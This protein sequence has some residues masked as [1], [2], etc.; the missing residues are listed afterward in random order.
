[1]YCTAYIVGVSVVVLGLVLSLKATAVRSRGNEAQTSRVAP[2]FSIA[3]LFLNLSSASFSSS[4]G[5]PL[6]HP[7]LDPSSTQHNTLTHTHTHILARSHALSQTLPHTYS[8]TLSRTHSLT[9]T[10]TLLAVNTQK[11]LSVHPK[12]GHTRTHTRKLSVC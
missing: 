5:F 8:P 1:M 7:A 12:C 4:G 9:H 2:F 3:T 11:H 10:L 6:H